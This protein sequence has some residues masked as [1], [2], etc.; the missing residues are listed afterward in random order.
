MGAKAAADGVFELDA[1][2]EGVLDDAWARGRDLLDAVGDVG[3]EFTRG[4]RGW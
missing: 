4:R 1:A 2:D 3:V